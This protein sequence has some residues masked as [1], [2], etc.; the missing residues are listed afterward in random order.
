M[1]ASIVG[2]FYVKTDEAGDGWNTNLGQLM[3]A[4]EKGIFVASAI[5]V[6]GALFLC[7]VMFGFKLGI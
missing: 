3:W 6:G 4:L 5:F 1:F 7:L 2:Y